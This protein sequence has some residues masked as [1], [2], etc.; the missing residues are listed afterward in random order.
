MVSGIDDRGRLS[1]MALGTWS[2]RFAEGA[3]VT[4]MSSSGTHRGTVLPRMASGHAYGSKVDE[5]P[6]SWEQVEVRGDAQGRT[7]AAARAHGIDVGDIVAFDASLETSPD[8]Y[9]NARHLDDKAGVAA[10]LTAARIVC[11]EGGPRRSCQLLFSVTEE[12]GTGAGGLVADSVDELV[13]VDIAI[14]APEQASDERAV[15]IARGDSSGPFD[16]AVADRLTQLARG[17]DIDARAD[18]FRHYRCD[19][20]AAITAGH[21]VRTAL[22]GFGVDASHGYERTHIDSLTNLVALLVAYWRDPAFVASS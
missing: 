20:A 5:Q 9:L 6:V 16:R 22:L 4:V 10:L 11:R 19:G 8:G 7:A 13:A 12:V 2:S 17:N 14:C 21:D 18:V 1:L 15:T 3:R